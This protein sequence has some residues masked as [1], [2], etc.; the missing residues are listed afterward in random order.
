M[1]MLPLVLTDVDL[2]LLLLPQCTRPNGDDASNKWA[3]PPQWSVEFKDEWVF[4]WASLLC[5]LFFFAVLVQCK[6]R[7]KTH[8]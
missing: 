2:L 8:M 1:F 5:R 3:P 6:R 4:R 7:F